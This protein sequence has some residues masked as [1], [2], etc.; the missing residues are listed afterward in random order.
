M[1]NKIKL[2]PAHAQHLLKLASCIGSHFDLATLSTI[3]GLPPKETARG[4]WKALANGL[5]VAGGDNYFV[6]MVSILLSLLRL[7]F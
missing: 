6:M 4:L 5:V 1:V 2:L 3:S 7:M